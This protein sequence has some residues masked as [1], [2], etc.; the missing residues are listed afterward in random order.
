MGCGPTS[1]VGRPSGSSGWEVPPVPAS[2]S[3][4]WERGQSLKQACFGFASH[5]YWLL[6]RREGFWFWHLKSSKWGV[7]GEV[8]SNLQAAGAGPAREEGGTSAEPCAPLR[9]AGIS[10]AEP[11]WSE[12]HP[13]RRWLGMFARQLFSEAIWRCRLPRLSPVLREALEGLPCTNPAGAAAF[14]RRGSLPRSAPWD[15]PA[16]P[17]VPGCPARGIASRAPPRPDQQPPAVTPRKGQPEG[18][19]VHPPPC[20]SKRRIREKIPNGLPRPSCVAPGTK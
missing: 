20:P 6:M 13:P 17:G 19:V 12:E 10:C 1:N 8:C 2:S 7:R 9:S 11:G 14:P 18:W 4:G 3:G 15:A 5:P 16:A